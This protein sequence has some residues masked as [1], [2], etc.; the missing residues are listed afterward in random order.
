MPADEINSFLIIQ[1]IHINNWLISNRIKIDTNKSN[2]IVYSYRKNI[3][4]PP[5]KM[6]DKFIIKPNS[7]PELSGDKNTGSKE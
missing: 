6:G 3:L 1:L 7:S 5:F 2:F 4:I